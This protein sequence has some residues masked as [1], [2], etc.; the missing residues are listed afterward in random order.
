MAI[1]SDA[2]YIGETVLHVAARAIHGPLLE[3][4]EPSQQ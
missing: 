1:V 4:Q 2:C 3:Q